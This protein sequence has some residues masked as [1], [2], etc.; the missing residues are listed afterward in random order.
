MWYSSVLCLCFGIISSNAQTLGGYCRTPT[1]ESAK[2]INVWSCNSLLPLLTAPSRTQEQTNFLVNSKCGFDSS[3]KPYVCCGSGFNPVGGTEDDAFSSSYTTNPAIPGRTQCGWQ[4]T[5]RIFNG[6]ATELDEF[7]W[8]VIIEYLKRD[9]RRRIACAGSLINR[10]YILTAAHCVKGAVFIKVG[11]PINVRLGEYNI[12]NPYRDC[13]MKKGI[14]SCNQPEI[15]AGIEELIPH[16]GYT[17]DV[18]NH[19]IALIR[20]NKNIPFS[21]YIQPV[22]LPKPDEAS[23]TGEKLIVA[24]WGRTEK[25]RDSDVKLKLEVPVT[26]NFSCAQKFGELN[27]QVGK[28]QMCAGSEDG[29]DSCSGDSGGPLMRTLPDDETRWMIEGIVSFGYTKCG[30]PGYPGVYTRVARYIPWIHRNVKP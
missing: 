29:K 22:C 11:Q 18:R 7:P 6:E 19:D 26:D 1:G 9:G 8:M 23:R 15:N 16:P 27:V 14:A 2:C 3:G 17:D 5:N 28:N 12:T 24:G 13:F 25:G 4:T 30:S 21:D 20:L 10:R